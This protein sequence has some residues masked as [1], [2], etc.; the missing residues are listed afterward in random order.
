MERD[1]N[2][3]TVVLYKIFSFFFYFNSIAICI[4]IF[5]N[6]KTHETNIYSLFLINICLN[7]NHT[8]ISIFWGGAVWQLGQTMWST[9]E[10]QTL[11]RARHFVVW[12]EWYSASAINI[13]SCSTIQCAMLRPVPSH[14][15]ESIRG[16]QANNICHTSTANTFRWNT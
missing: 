1:F 3:T 7:V 12:R 8:F 4:A 5:L 9:H 2:R 16:L 14:H 11:S 6:N 15:M 10:L 13:S